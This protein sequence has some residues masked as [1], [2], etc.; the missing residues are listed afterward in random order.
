MSDLDVAKYE[1]EHMYFQQKNQRKWVIK[2]EMKKW[3]EKIKILK[4]VKCKKERMNKRGS[5]RSNSKI[6]A[7]SL[8]NEIGF[9]DTRNKK[10]TMFVYQDIWGKKKQK[11]KGKLFQKRKKNI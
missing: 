7:V 8:K 11:K 1:S 6:E 9:D 10:E 2:S 5:I 4:L 3:G